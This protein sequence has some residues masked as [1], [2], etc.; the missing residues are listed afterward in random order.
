[1][2]KILNK[3]CELKGISQSA[4]SNKLGRSRGFVKSVKNGVE[5]QMLFNLLALYPDLNPYY[6]ITG[7]GEPLIDDAAANSRLRRAA[8]SALDYKTLYEEIRIMY[9][10]VLTANRHMETAIKNL[11]KQNKGLIER[12]NA[13]ESNA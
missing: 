11:T 13:L 1:M 6:L 4:L 2:K 5:D 12:C 9:D 8:S 7:K 10:D 3:V